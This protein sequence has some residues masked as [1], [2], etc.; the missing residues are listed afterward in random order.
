MNCNRTSLHQDKVGNY[1]FGK[2]P[3]FNFDV[4]NEGVITSQVR[5]TLY[6]MLRGWVQNPSEIFGFWG[7]GLGALT[8][9]SF[10]A[11][12]RG[13]RWFVVAVIRV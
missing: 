2:T 1:M 9:G 12:A 5:H 6:A 8:L 3:A 10:L 7:L 11:T 4:T 13:Y